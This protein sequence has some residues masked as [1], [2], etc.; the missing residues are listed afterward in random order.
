VQVE[1]GPPDVGAIHNVLNGDRLVAAFADQLDQRLLQPFARALYPPVRLRH[2]A[3]SDEQAYSPRA[4]Q[5]SSVR[6]LNNSLT[7]FTNAR[8]PRFGY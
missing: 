3:A 6:F 2:A 4:G 5:A 1:G 8:I 7:L